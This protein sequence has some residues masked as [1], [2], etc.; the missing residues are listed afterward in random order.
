MNRLLMRSLR[1][2]GRP[3]AGEGAEPAAAPDPVAATL[4]AQAALTEIVQLAQQIHVKSSLAGALALVAR[5]LAPRLG[6]SAAVVLRVV[7]WQADGVLVH[8]WPPELAE[9]T[10]CIDF[11]ALALTRPDEWPLGHALAPGMLAGPG[12]GSFDFVEQA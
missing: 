1:G 3:A 12:L 11:D 4:D 9:E 10:D 7:D 5:Q 6:A 8:P 2:I